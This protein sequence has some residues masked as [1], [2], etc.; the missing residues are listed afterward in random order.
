[1]IGLGLILQIFDFKWEVTLGDILLG[2]VGG[3]ASIIY[4]IYRYWLPRRPFILRFYEKPYDTDDEENRPIAW[5]ICKCRIPYDQPKFFIGVK[6]RTQRTIKVIDIR[7]VERRYFFFWK[8]ITKDKVAILRIKDQE[9]H[10]DGWGPA[11]SEGADNKK[12][13]REGKYREPINDLPRGAILWYEIQAWPKKE[14]NGWL[15]FQLRRG[16]S[17]KGIARAKICFRHSDLVGR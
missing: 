2:V 9:R 8:E 14:W 15:S 17:H 1:M 7:L 11:I 3:T 13:G 12:G 16:S 5:H 10:F 6:L 4:G